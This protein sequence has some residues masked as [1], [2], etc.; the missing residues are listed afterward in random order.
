MFYR[1][2]VIR[3]FRCE[4]LSCEIAHAGQI[5]ERREATGNSYPLDLREKSKVELVLSITSPQF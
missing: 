2:R 3:N 4:I 5:K 1:E